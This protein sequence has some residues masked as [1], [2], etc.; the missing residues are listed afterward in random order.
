MEERMPTTLG[1]LRRLLMS[2]QLVDVTLAQRGFPAIPSAAAQRL[3]AIPQAVIC[4]FGWGIDA[5]NQWVVARSIDLAHPALRGFPYEGPPMPWSTPAPPGR[6][7][8]T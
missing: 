2:P 1:S 4:G 6:R 5:R 3:E 7:H 8:R